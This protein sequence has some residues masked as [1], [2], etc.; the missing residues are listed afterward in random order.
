MSVNW[1]AL[2][3][4]MFQ[5]TPPARGAIVGE[6]R[7][8][9]ALL[10]SIHAP[11]AGGDAKPDPVFQRQHWFQS[12]PPA[13]G[14]ISG[15]VAQTRSC[16]CFNPRPPRGGRCV[17]ALELARVRVFQSAPPARGAIIA[18]VM[19]WANIPVSI[20]APRAGGDWR[21]TATFTRT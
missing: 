11:R 13:R 15:V 7:R 18:D 10:V 20:R 3:N 8:R 12:A 2:V 4:D 5:S 6:L 14:A 19:E 17:V 1:R 21:W 9:R 16:V